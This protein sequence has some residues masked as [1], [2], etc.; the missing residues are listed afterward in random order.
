[1]TLHCGKRLTSKRPAIARQFET[2]RVVSLA[3]A[4]V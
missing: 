3:V 4:R 1:M 2:G